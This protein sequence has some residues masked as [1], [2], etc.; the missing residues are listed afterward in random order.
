[1]AGNITEINFAT[2]NNRKALGIV[3]P[4]AIIFIVLTIQRNEDWLSNYSLFSADVKNAPRCCKLNFN[5][6]SDIIN[7]IANKEQDP[8]KKKMMTAEGIGS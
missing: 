2:A 5:L 7:N 1:M 6:G 4:I 3:A 8:Q